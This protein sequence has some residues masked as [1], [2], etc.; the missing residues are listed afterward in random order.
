[1]RWESHQRHAVQDRTGQ[2]FP[3]AVLST[4]PM[5][6]ARAA[7]C[8]LTPTAPRTVRHGESSL[9][10]CSLGISV[11]DQLL[12][13][14]LGNPLQGLGS[15]GIHARRAPHDGSASAP[16]EPRLF[17]LSTH[18]DR[19]V[20]YSTHRTLRQA[21]PTSRVGPSSCI[22]GVSTPALSCQP[23][24]GTPRRSNMQA[25]STPPAEEDAPATAGAPT[26]HR[27]RRDRHAAPV[28]QGQDRF[29]DHATIVTSY[30]AW[31]AASAHKMPCSNPCTVPVPP[32]DYKRE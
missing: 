23:G 30:R 27:T 29:I 1:M 31:R 3:A 18:S 15:L 6:D 12:P 32:F 17:T 10:P 22:L 2:G 16:T 9:G 26:S 28:H 20:V 24:L 11:Q 13:P 14:S 25:T 19:H 4:V 7:L 8:C 21:A 5:T